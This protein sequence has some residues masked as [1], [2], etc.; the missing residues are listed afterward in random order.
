MAIG[1]AFCLDIGETQSHDHTEKKEKYVLNLDCI[2][3][4][5]ETHLWHEAAQS[6]VN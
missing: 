6:V 4:Q 3:F 2:V 5:K 1:V